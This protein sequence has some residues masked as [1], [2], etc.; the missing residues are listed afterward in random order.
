MHGPK[1]LAALWIIAATGS[2]C[3]ILAPAA[4][5]AVTAT[6]YGGAS[7]TAAAAAA[8]S[9]AT[10]NAAATDATCAR[11]HLPQHLSFR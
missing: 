9:A 2:L 5:P 11:L 10:T 8:A 6:A 4:A 7:A 1:E 3:N